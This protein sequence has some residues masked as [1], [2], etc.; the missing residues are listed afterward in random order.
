MLKCSVIRV[1]SLGSFLGS[2]TW[3]KVARAWVRW[4]LGEVEAAEIF[5]LSMA[6]TSLFPERLLWCV[7][8]QR[9]C[10]ASPE[11]WGNKYVQWKFKKLKK[12][13]FFQH[14]EKVVQYNESIKLSPNSN[15]TSVNYLMYFFQAFSKCLRIDNLLPPSQ[16]LLPC[17]FL[18]RKHAAIWPRILPRPPACSPTSMWTSPPC[19]RR[20]RSFSVKANSFPVLLTAPRVS[21]TL[22]SATPSPWAR[23]LSIPPI[24]G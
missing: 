24:A 8:S 12:K 23:A 1:W 14:L 6:A 2:I 4:I 13:P 22:C 17:H 21:P 15:S 7:C 9:Y 3:W 20:F 10:P 18:H 5:G 19:L 16:K 11:S